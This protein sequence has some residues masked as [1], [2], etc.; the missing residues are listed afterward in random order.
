MRGKFSFLLFLASILVVPTGLSAQV[1]YTGRTV[2]PLQLFGGYSYIFRPYDHTQANPFSGGMNGWDAA[3]RVP[4]PLFGSW[5]GVDG[6]VSGS[7]RNDSPNFN[8]HSYFFLRG[9]CV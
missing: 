7:Y 3:L 5:L 1:P 9:G 8:P 6:D 2:P 4:V